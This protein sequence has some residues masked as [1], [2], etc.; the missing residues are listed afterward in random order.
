MTNPVR[1]QTIPTIF[2]K[3]SESSDLAK[4]CTSH[5]GQSIVD[6]GLIDLDILLTRTRHAHS[7]VRF[8]DA[9]KPTAERP[10]ASSRDARRGSL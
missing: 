9:V 3:S 8:L 5:P 4:H 1:G 10:G 7:D 6:A 2:A